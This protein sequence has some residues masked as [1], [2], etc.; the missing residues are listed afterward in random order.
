MTMLEEKDLGPA[1]LNGFTRR[2]N[3][4][5]LAILV[6][7]IGTVVLFFWL[8]LSFLGW[9]VVV[10]G[11]G[12]ICFLFELRGQRCPRCRGWVLWSGGPNDPDA[13]CPETPGITILNGPP[14]QCRGCGVKLRKSN[15]GSE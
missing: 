7:G 9:M 15:A 11:A 10:F 4:A 3:Q 14:E 6:V 5:R 13:P 1:E 2:Y 8:S 12:V